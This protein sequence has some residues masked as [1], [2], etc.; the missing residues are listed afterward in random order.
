MNTLVFLLAAYGLCFALMNEKVKWFTDPLKSLRLF[1]DDNDAT[2]FQRMF[3]CAFCTGFHC[4]WV[5]WCIGALPHF[6]MSSEYAVWA[7]IAD[8]IPFAFAS[9]AFCYVLD[10]IVQWFE[11]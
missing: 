8:A 10:T 1:V 5:I 11:E 7:M 6:L 3:S 4:G 2:F 9:S